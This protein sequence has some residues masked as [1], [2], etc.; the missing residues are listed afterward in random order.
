[1]HTLLFG[2][3]CFLVSPVILYLAAKQ[4]PKVKAKLFEILEDIDNQ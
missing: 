4:F 1:M 2:I 3:I